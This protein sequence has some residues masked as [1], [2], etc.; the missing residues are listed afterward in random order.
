MAKL[1]VVGSGSAGNSYIIQ[2]EKETLLLELGV[3]WDKIL[4]ALNYKIKDVVGAL[5]T[6][7]H[8][9]HSKSISHAI[10]YGIDVYSNKDVV[11]R[12]KGTKLLE[13]H[14]K[15][16]IGGFKVQ[17]IHVEH[18]VENYAYLIEH[19]ELGRLLFITD[20]VSFPYNVKNI[21]HLM[22]EANNSEEV[23]LNNMCD[24]KTTNSCSEFH[25]E[26][27][28]TIDAICRLFNPNMNTIMLVHLSAFQSDENAFRNMVLD[29]VGIMPYIAHENVIVELSKEDF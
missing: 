29:E 24:G 13:I 20:A 28:N 8:K 15:Y 21:N 17:P 4:G 10:E 26:I 27:N 18:N 3:K 19:D 16:R 23:I 6:H 11:S 25:M 2:T 14:K 22:I 7:V 9:D 1:I 12:H 5:V